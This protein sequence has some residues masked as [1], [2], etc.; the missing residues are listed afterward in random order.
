MQRGRL[1]PSLLQVTSRRLRHVL[2]VNEL[3]THGVEGR[4][5]VPDD[6]IERLQLIEQ[7]QQIADASG[8]TAE[9]V[10]GRVRSV[11]YR[12]VKCDS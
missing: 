1:S 6:G 7:L 5:R 8:I 12:A 3:G 2:P 9:D 10:R 4:N 11:T